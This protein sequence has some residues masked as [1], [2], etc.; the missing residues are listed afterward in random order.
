[1]IFIL[2]APKKHGHIALIVLYNCMSINSI[3]VPST[4]VYLV[5]CPNLPKQ[6]HSFVPPPPPDVV[7]SCHTPYS[8]Q[9]T[10]STDSIQYRVMVL[11]VFIS[12][13]QLANVSAICPRFI[14]SMYSTT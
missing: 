5:S 7:M 12:I 9:Y 1:M 13:F 4:V 8:I 10:V 11:H 14:D 6:N 2:N 3:S